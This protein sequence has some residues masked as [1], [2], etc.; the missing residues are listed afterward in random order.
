MTDFVCD[1]CGKKGPYIEDNGYTVHAS[2]F[3]EYE[4]YIRATCNDCGTEVTWTH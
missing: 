2:F 1:G 3:D 4:S